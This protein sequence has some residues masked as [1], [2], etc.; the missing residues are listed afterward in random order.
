MPRCPSAGLESNACS[1]RSCWIGSLEQR[2]NS[3]ISREILVWA[4][5]RLLR[6]ISLEFHL[7]PPNYFNRTHPEGNGRTRLCSNCCDIARKKVEVRG[8][9]LTAIL[10]RSQ[11]RFL[12]EELRKMAG[13]CVSNIKSDVYYAFLCLTQQLASSIHSQIKLKT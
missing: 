3:Y 8:L 6:S 11:S 12:V 7:N 2:I 10:A 9:T 13:V 5:G 4:F 1:T